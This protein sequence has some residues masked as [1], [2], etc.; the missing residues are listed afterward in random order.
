MG[1]FIDEIRK[2]NDISRQNIIKSF[3]GGQDLIAKAEGNELDEV[4]VELFGDT[5]QKAVYADTPQNRKLGRVGQEYHRGKGKKEEESKPSRTKLEKVGVMSWLH[6]NGKHKYISHS[7]NYESGEGGKKDFVKE[8]KAYLKKNGETFDPS[9]LSAKKERGYDHYKH[10]IYT[11][12]LSGSRDEAEELDKQATIAENKKKEKEYENG[13]AEWEKK[14]KLAEDI[15]GVKRWE[16]LPKVG[17]YAT[18]KERKKLYN[19]NR[20]DYEEGLIEVGKRL[21][22]EGKI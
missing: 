1:N 11:Y 22:K 7:T 2:H 14:N 17:R 21:R 10:T 18:E 6:T 3:G 13:Y 9:K 15:L 4:Y 12:T 20:I 19:G 8:V 5:I 16:L